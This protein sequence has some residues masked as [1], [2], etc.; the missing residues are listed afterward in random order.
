[1]LSA[2]DRFD[3]LFFRVAKKYLDN[4]KGVDVV[5][6]QDDLTLIEGVA[7]LAYVPPTGSKWTI[8]TL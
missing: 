5:V 3:G 8:Q 2:L 4:V 7:P 6:M 1:V